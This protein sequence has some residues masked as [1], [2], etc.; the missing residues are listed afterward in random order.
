[1]LT[2]FESL[3]PKNIGRIL[4][5]SFRLCRNHWVTFSLITVLPYLVAFGAYHLM[6]LLE[7]YRFIS[8]N[9]GPTLIN[10]R[11]FGVG[12]LLLRAGDLAFLMWAGLVY[13]FPAG[14]LIWATSEAYLG[15]SL[16]AKEAF[17]VGFKRYLPL[18]GCSFFMVAIIG[19]GIL[20][21]IVPGIIWAL[22]FVLA[23]WAVVLENLSPVGAL[24]R[25]KRL[26][27]GHVWRVVLIGIVLGIVLIAMTS[28]ASH[29]YYQGARLFL[30]TVR[31]EL[32][33]QWPVWI[34]AV[35]MFLAAPISM[36]IS[37]FVLGAGTILYYDLRVRKEG[38]DLELRAQ[39]LLAQPR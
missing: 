13:L 8:F 2:T 18:L 22:W 25:A 21:L 9:W 32:P 7:Y 23:P 37:W 14:A 28:F 16:K 34:F 4:D 15:R 11:L 29:L 5:D 30:Q 17:R 24:R 3:R 31:G 6:W 27:Q 1:M 35:A 20:L 26:I 19:S 12:L 36:F 33:G 38:F 10:L 39:E